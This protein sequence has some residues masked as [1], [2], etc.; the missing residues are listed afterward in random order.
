MNSFI[1]TFCILRNGQVITPSGSEPV[2]ASGTTEFLARLY[3][4][5]HPSYPKFYKMDSLSKAGFLAAEILLKDHPLT[6]YKPAA[7]AVVLSNASG[8]LDTDLHFEHSIHTM[9]SPALFVYTLPNIVAGE[10]CIRHKIN[11]E[12][13][14]FIAPAFDAPVMEEYVAQLFVQ[15]HTQACIAGWVEVLEDSYDV[16][17]YLIEKEKRG[18]GLPH[19]AGE[20]IKLYAQ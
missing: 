12:N 1:T 6:A 16:F 20:L 15:E 9:A 17:L 2:G 5:I 13:A 4:D 19:R 11:G 10:L 3:N 7:V 14:F 8:S 18:L